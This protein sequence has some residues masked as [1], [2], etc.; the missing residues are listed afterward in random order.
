[1]ISAWYCGVQATNTPDDDWRTGYDRG[2]A[3][4]G[5]V[6]FDGTARSLLIL[7]SFPRRLSIRAISLPG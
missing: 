5:R 7:T 2:R 4:M 1:M 6:T 3:V